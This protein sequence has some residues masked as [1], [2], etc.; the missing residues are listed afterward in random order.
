VKE[1]KTSTLVVSREAGEKFVLK[2]NDTVLLD[3]LIVSIGSKKVTLAFRVAENV[4][5]STI[6]K[7]MQ[8]SKS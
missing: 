7:L 3:L 1:N 6:N 4:K 8:K 5:I 2:I